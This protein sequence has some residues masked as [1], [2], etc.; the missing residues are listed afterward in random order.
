MI[1]REHLVIAFELLS[2]NLYDFLK[3]NNFQGVS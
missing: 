2:L 3:Q 1:F